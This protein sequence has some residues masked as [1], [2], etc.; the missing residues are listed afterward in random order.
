MVLADDTS[1]YIEENINDVKFH[2]V[3]GGA[4]AVL[5]IFF[6]LRNVTATLISAV[7]IPTSIIG[8]FYVI[9]WFDFSLNML[10]MLAL[11]LS[12]GILIDDAIVVIEN[13]FRHM[14]EGRPRRDAAEFATSEIGLAV[15][16][17]TFSI[18]AV[19][20]PVLLMGGLIGRLF[21]E[22]AVTISIAILVSGFVSLTLTPMLCS[23]FLRPSRNAQHGRFYEATERIYQRV[24]AAYERSL[25]WVMDHRPAALA[26]SG[27]ILGGTVVL[28]VLVPK[29]FIP[30][31]DN[32]S[33]AGN[34]ETVEG[35]SF[36]AMRDH[37]LAVA[38]LLV[39][40]R[41]K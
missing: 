6:F 22:F 12:V 23:R 27:A 18:V 39:F 36:E 16:A 14:E 5:V 32:G 29:G 24:L 20:I 2:L 34:T 1:E 25:V 21:R 31:E 37:Q 19:F 3:F 28:F 35:S 4:L 15:M 40:K 8:T 7:A 26:F 33:I 13:I 9:D 11:S 10:T 30:T 41:A 38:S 17:T